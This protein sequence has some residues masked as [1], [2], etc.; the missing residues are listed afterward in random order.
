MRRRPRRSRP[1]ILRVG[2][3][4]ATAVLLVSALV[5][6]SGPG[7]GKIR[8]ALILKEFTNPYWISMESA[9]R[10]EAA[11]Q[12]MYLQVSAGQTDDDTASQINEVDEAIA[13]G[14]KGIIIALNG[15]AVDNAL[16]QAKQYG[17]T[18]IA[19][20]TAPVP[21]STADVTYATD[22]RQ[23]GT[24]IGKWM[25]TK[26]AGK[27]ADIAMLDDLGDQVITV[28]V[29][30]DHGFLDGMGIPV[31]NQ[32]INGQEPKSG[33][34]RGGKGGSY[35]I[36]CQLPTE[37]AQTGGQSAMETCLSKDSG[38]NVVYAI[39][40]PSAEGAAMALKAAGK[41]GV[42]IVTVDGGCANLPFL[43]NGEIAATAGQFPDKMARL[44]VDAVATFAKT[45]RRP[46]NQPGKDYFNTG[47]KLYT[48]D[49]Q[50][51]VPSVNTKTAARLCW[52]GKS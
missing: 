8:V 35:K 45:G 46:R 17:I 4:A 26:L 25:A 9:A 44:G 33:T 47:T 28:D 10:A 11:K 50:H 15:D 2:A 32:H 29:D 7:G 23:A 42:T 14:V 19:L 38:I 39:N 48:A 34:Y 43:R 40:E 13:E 1:P 30:R 24:L 22:N 52:G 31:G 18:V 49:P 41:K 12:G 36:A 20:D 6:C 37:G 3:V 27:P 16:D 5:A 21:P 51:G